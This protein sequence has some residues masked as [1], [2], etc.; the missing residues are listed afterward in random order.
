MKIGF[1]YFIENCGANCSKSDIIGT[2]TFCVGRPAL[3]KKKFTENYKIYPNFVNNV[4]NIATN[5]N[6]EILALEITDI[7]GRVVIKTTN[8]GTSIDTNDL[9]T[10]VY[11]IKINTAEGSGTSKFVKL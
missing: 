4:L 11:F 6:L 9:K 1:R 7:N 3:S 8:N 10:G 2:D 5:N